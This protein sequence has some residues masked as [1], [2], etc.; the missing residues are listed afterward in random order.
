[1]SNYWFRI[2]PQKTYYFSDFGI[3]FLDNYG[4]CWNILE[5]PNGDIITIDFWEDFDFW[6]RRGKDGFGR[7]EHDSH[8]R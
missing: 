5:G 7:W 4:H 3:A 8:T 6:W 1:M 2:S